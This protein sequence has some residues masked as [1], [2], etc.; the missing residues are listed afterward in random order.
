MRP[1]IGDAPEAQRALA[2]RFGQPRKGADCRA[3][4]IPE[5]F[6]NFRISLSNFEKICKFAFA[7]YIF[8]REAGEER[9]LTAHKWAIFYKT[10][11]KYIIYNS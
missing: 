5:C 10:L 3:I 8:L 9:R 4:E 7:Y 6:G 11:L 2:L 1:G